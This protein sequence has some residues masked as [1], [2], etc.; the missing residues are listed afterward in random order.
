MLGI[1]PDSTPDGINKSLGFG[2][3]LAKE[4]FEYLPADKGV[5]LILYITLVLLL[6][7]QG[8]I[9]QEGSRKRNLVWARVTSSGK[10]IFALLEEI[11]TFQVSFI[12][13][14]FREPSFQKLLMWAFIV[15]SSGD[16]RG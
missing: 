5:S 12:P 2:Q 13:I 8:G 10:V 15:R 1:L 9:F 14:N 16:N 4:S 3:A 11:I 7:E 6:A